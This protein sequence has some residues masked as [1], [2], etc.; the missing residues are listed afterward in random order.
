VVEAYILFYLEQP[1]VIPNESSSTL[2][3]DFSRIVTME[4]LRL[5]IIAI[6]SERTLGVTVQ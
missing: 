3:M 6:E 5:A 4:L 1:S 2:M